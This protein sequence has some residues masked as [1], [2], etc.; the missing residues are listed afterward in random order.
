MDLTER[1]IL[2]ASDAIDKALLRMNK[3]NRGETAVNIL[4]VVRNL[5]DHIA[6]K[7][8]CELEPTTPR[9]I[10]KVASLFINKRGLQFI[11][12]FDRF[13]R[14]SVSHFTP[15]E[16]GAERLMLKYFK[17]IFELKSLM[18]KRYNIDIIKNI[19]YFLEDLDKQTQ[20]Y[21]AAVAD[22]INNIKSIPNDES[23]MDNYYINRIKPF[24]VK[25]KIYFEVTLEPAT[26]KPNKFNRITAFTKHDMM[27]NYCVA[28]RF[29]RS[30]IYALGAHIPIVII[31]NWRVSIRPCEFDNFAHLIKIESHIERGHL[32]Y[33]SFMT[34]L[35]DMRVSLI[36]I[37]DY[38][39]NTYT[40]LKEEI[41]NST[42]NKKS[43]IFHILDRCREI[44]QN[45]I[46]GK[47]IIR[48]LL[49][50]MYNTYIKNQ[51]ADLGEKKFINTNIS[52]KC[53]P[54][55]Q[56]PFSFYPHVNR[57][58]LYDLLES[59]DYAG[60]EPEFLARKIINNTEENGQLYTPISELTTFG[61][62]N[63][64]R[65]TVAQYNTTL[66]SGF[67]PNSELGLYGEYLYNKGEEIRLI[68]ILQK[69]KVLSETPT[70]FSELFSTKQVI[71]LKNLDFPEQLDDPVKENILCNLFSSSRI[72]F[73]YGS[74]GTGKSTLINHIAKL[75]SGYSRVFLAKTNPA[76]ENLRRKI[77]VKE[78][79]DLFLTINKF[80]ARN[81]YKHK[82]FDLIVIDE[83]ST[84]ENEDIEKLIER[85]GEGVMV[86]AGDIFQI[87]AIGFGNWFRIAKSMMPQRC[88][89]EL[90]FPFRSPDKELKKLWDEVR[91]IDAENVVLENIVRNDY[92]HIIDKSIFDKKAE[93]EII[94]CLNYNGL[95]GL[96]NIN[97]L[98]QQGNPN[99]AVE[100]G[101]WQFRIN[102]PIL[103]NDSERFSALYNNL[104]GRILDFIDRGVH[105]QFTI[106]VEIPLTKEEITGDSGLTLLDSKNGK[107]IV[108]FD[109]NRRAPYA[110][111]R[112]AA[113]KGHILPFQVAY[114]VSI[115]K[116]QGL[117][118]DSVKIVIADD[119][120][121][122]ITHSIFY[123]AITRTKLYLTLF[124]SPEV[125]NRILKSLQINDSDRD[126][127]CLKSKFPNLFITH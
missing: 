43:V 4:T 65:K 101:I 105:V 12:R 62:S 112:E 107:S 24:F 83:C 127:A 20:E 13:L 88:W 10:N 100:I 120:E 117:E 72:H 102:D 19:D 31:S 80:L 99:K 75:M 18:K 46:T 86:L 106:E 63:Q 30:S 22:Q 7:L 41:I 42:R 115:H 125:C 94:L 90:T 8:W 25:G 11:W 52:T 66:Y 81:I 37:I 124:W 2:K 61:D 96:N 17:Y 111:D 60:R 69:L 50:N 98:L 9:D 21:Y 59:I 114:A 109:V 93:D 123:T 44:C 95:Y 39:W 74:A 119:S 73:I 121:D 71:A 40:T 49:N 108:Q 14:K 36:D 84:V 92:S 68:N 118:Y 29:C 103:F 54:F 104:K 53:Y 32:E 122:R 89:S 3:T 51:T 16:D 79:N 78:E 87:Q 45:N 116:S 97:K 57:S 82:A 58:N 70:P 38:D 27:Q 55:E 35:T 113:E 76:V 33:R 23:G 26:E 126:V 110:S 77:I 47:Y 85:L 34:Y 6:Y 91:K 15:S 1:E 5:N 48:Y 56:H 64:I 28:L 67:R